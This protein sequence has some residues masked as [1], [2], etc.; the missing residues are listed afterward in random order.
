MS[1]TLLTLAMALSVLAV[2]L[3]RAPL[4]MWFAA[5]DSAELKQA[6]RFITIAMVLFL[7]AVCFWGALPK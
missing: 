2:A 6:S 4:Q 5:T 7:A 1:L 3:G